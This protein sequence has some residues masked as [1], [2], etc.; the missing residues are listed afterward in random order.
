[1]LCALPIL[2]LISLIFFTIAQIEGSING[3]ADSE[4]NEIISKKLADFIDKNPGAVNNSAGKGSG[5]H[6]NINGESLEQI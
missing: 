2:I 1:M 6:A 4:V 3:T 5:A